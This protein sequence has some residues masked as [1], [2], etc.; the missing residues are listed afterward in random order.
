MTVTVA[1]PFV[2]F[3]EFVNKIDS[4]VLGC[5]TP[6]FRGPFIVPKKLEV[7]PQRISEGLDFVFRHDF[8]VFILEKQYQ[9][10]VL[11]VDKDLAVPDF[12]PRLPIPVCEGLKSST[13]EAREMF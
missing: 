8:P 6:A 1:Q 10:W 2:F 13:L 5:V 11:G 4:E 7:R 12:G 9:D 3:L